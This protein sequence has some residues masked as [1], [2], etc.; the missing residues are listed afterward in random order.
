MS[1]IATDFLPC[2]APNIVL[3]CSQVFDEAVA[4]FNSNFGVSLFISS[5][6]CNYYENIHNYHSLATEGSDNEGL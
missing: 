1:A 6:A 5:F 3:E 4:N 2:I